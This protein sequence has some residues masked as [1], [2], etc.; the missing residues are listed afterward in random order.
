MVAQS[1]FAGLDLLATAVLLLDHQLVVQYANPAA[2]NLFSLNRKALPQTSFCQLLAGS[3]TFHKTLHA[4]IANHMSYNEHE[5]TLLSLNHVPLQVGC[6][7]TPIDLDSLAVML[8]FRQLEQQLRVVREERFREQQ[9]FNHEL[10]RNLAHEI[11][12]PLG[13]IRGAA[14]LLEM[15]LG[16]GNLLEYTSVII[17][18]TVRLQSLLDRLITPHKLPKFTPLNIHEI[19]ERVKSL[20]LAESK[21]GLKISRDY[22]VSLPEIIGDK[23]QL[24]QAILNIA[25]NSAQVLG[26]SGEIILK[27]RIA[28][29]VTIAKVRHR[30]AAHI[31]II[32]DGPGVPEQ[33][34]DKIFYPLVTGREGGSGLGL[35]LAQR[36]IH[37]HQGSIEF[38]SRP[39][40]TCFSILLPIAEGH[41]VIKAD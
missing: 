39:G 31:T 24:M 26:D 23:E 22:D 38:T 14:Q 40:Q 18:E 20:I 27:T 35:S 16:E 15:E 10:I 32:D 29:Q 36:Y 9:E 28:R 2:E 8:E 30:H 21:H 12:N 1:K 11:R 19:M 41:K 13:G 5:L 25:R 17:D 37:H 7:I 33:I 3:D 4:A 34:R 6:T